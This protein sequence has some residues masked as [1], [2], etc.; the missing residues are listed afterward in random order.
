MFNCAISLAGDCADFA[1]ARRLAALAD[2]IVAADGG[3]DLL[4]KAEIAPDW[5]IGDNDSAQMSLPAE[6]KRI[7]FPQDKNYTDGELAISL[8]LYL[9]D[10][11]NDSNKKKSLSRYISNFSPDKNSSFAASESLANSLIDNFR[12]AENLSSYSFLVLFP[13]GQR[14]DHTWTNVLLAASLARLGA[15]VYLSDGLTMVRVVAGKLQLQPVFEP[16]VLEC[17]AITSLNDV[18]FSAI[19]LDDNVEGFSLKGLKWELDQTRLAY[20]MTTA[21]SN[22][23][24]AGE[25]LAPTLTLDAGTVMLVLTPAN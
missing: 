8:A 14:V 7:L 10:S 25:K 4:L 5:V 15:L 16:E 17:S 22:R 13:F 11:A 18:A 1:A 23:S 24:L 6:T 2:I 20:N 12:Q 19:P 9:A 3:A 21:V